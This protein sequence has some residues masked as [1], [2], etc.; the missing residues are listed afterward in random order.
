MAVQYR[1]LFINFRWYSIWWQYNI[2]IYLYISGDIVFD[3]RQDIKEKY[4]YSMYDMTVRGSCSC[5]GHASRCIPVDGY[6][7]NPSMVCII[8]IVYISV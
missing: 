5:Y 1:W 8:D 6:A 3:G 2:D 7:N 4:Y